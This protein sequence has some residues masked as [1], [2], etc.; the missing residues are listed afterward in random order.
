MAAP[1]I[2]DGD[3][4][5]TPPCAPSAAAPVSSCGAVELWSLQSLRD[6]MRL[7]TAAFSMLG[8]R[9]GSR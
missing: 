2:A 9:F 6:R 4:T 1:S 3:T 7:V 5:T 8:A